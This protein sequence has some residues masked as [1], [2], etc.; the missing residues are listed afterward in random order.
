MVTGQWGGSMCLTEPGAGTDVGNLSTK[1]IRQ[2]DG[3]F[4][5]QGTKMFITGGDQDLTENII[6]PVLARIEGDPAGT[7]G[8]SIFIVP[9]FLVNEDGS[10]GRRNDFE[11]A[12]IEE[13]MGIHGSSTC[14]INFGDNNNCYGELMGGRARGHEG[15]VPDDERGQDRHRAAGPLERFRCLPPC[16]EL[17]QGA[18]PGIIAAGIQEPRC[19]SRTHHLSTLM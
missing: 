8:I 3:T 15:H 14:V 12:K 9:K 1:A 10:L 11:I 16:T 17:Y 5:L 2:P 19:P 4:K 18:A 7:K 6:H 13:K